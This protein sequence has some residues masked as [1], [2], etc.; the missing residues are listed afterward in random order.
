MAD[1]HLFVWHKSIAIAV[2]A[3]SL[4]LLSSCSMPV[5]RSG[6]QKFTLPVNLLVRQPNRDSNTSKVQDLIVQKPE[7]YKQVITRLA[8]AQK[9]QLLNLP[10]PVEF[11]GKKFNDIKFKSKNKALAQGESLKPIALTFDDG[12][13]EKSTSQVLDVLKK[14]DIKA[15]F[16]VVGRQVERYPQLIKQ[17][18]AEGHALG[19]HTWSHQYRMY[20]SAA[21]AR[22]I[23]KTA[24]LVYKTTGVKTSLFRPPGGFLNNGLAAY[25][26][27]KKYAVVMWSADSLDWRYRQPTTLIDRVLK[28]ASAGGIVLMHDGGGDRSKTVQA[29]PEVIA[30]LRKRGYS[31]VTVP[32]LLEIED[33]QLIANKN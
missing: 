21:A 17:I 12:P 20:N 5:A 4:G 3:T 2:V 10:L 8:D 19:N 33:K 7:A 14:E 32:E 13:W 28:E 9:A 15:T 6:D 23:D 1:H 31:F 18:V 27:Q 30:Q 26:Y 29:L 24:E 22:E 25:A 11:Q 16:F